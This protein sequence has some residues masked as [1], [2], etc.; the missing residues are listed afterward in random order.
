MKNINSKKIIS[1]IVAVSLVATTVASTAITAAAQTLDS[2]SRVTIGLNGVVESAQGKLA[3]TL[4]SENTT[5]TGISSAKVAVDAP[6]NFAVTG[7]D[8]KVLING[9]SNG[10]TYNLIISH[11][12]YETKQVSYTYNMDNDQLDS[13]DYFLLSNTPES[14][15]TPTPQA[16]EKPKPIIIETVTDTVEIQE[17]IINESAQT[18]SDIIIETEKSDGTKTEI[19]IP[20]FSEHDV[21]ISGENDMWVTTANETSEIQLHS[22]VTPTQQ[23]AVAGIPHNVIRAATAQDATVVANFHTAGEIEETIVLDA[24]LFTSSAYENADFSIEYDTQTNDKAIVFTFS[25]EHSDEQNAIIAAQ[26]F[27]KASADGLDLKIRINSENNSDE[28]LYEWS[29][30]SEDI[31]DVP[32]EDIDLYITENPA[33]DIQIESLV[34]GNKAQCLIISY[35]GQ[36]PAP[37]TLRVKN[38]S[39]F[40]DSSALTLVYSNPKTGELEVIEEGMKFTDDGYISLKLEH[41]SSYALVD[42]NAPEKSNYAYIGILA[43]ALVGLLFIRKNRKVSDCTADSKTNNTD[44]GSN[45]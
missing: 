22:E 20:K 4:H 7:E 23:T 26:A 8:G 34:D 12:G 37:A 14:T 31:K 25:K 18:G 45:G 38:L 11:E 40:S 17:D 6:D 16:T 1:I 30:N 41:C 29:F 3:I 32:P 33:Q 13:K 39:K 9:L 42:Y 43:I 36:L 28:L 2:N 21:E 15:P 5:G 24:E 44:G 35:H 10:A 19:T 27:S